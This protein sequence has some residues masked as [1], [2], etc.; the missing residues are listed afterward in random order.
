V[1]LV[2]PTLNNFSG[3]IDLMKSAQNGSLKPTCIVVWDNSG[4]KGFTDYCEQVGFS[5]AENVVVIES[6]KN[7]GCAYPWNK[8]IELC[9]KNYPKE[10]VCVS[11]DDI[12]LAHDT[13]EVFDKATR[14]RDSIL[15]CSGGIAA[16]NAFS[17][18]V[19]RYDRMQSVGVFDEMFIYPYCE[20]SDMARRIWFTGYDLDRV[21][22]CTIES[23][24][25]SATIKAYD[26]TDEEL[27]HI[28]FRRNAEYFYMKWG[29]DHNHIAVEYG[30]KEPWDGD[31]T[32]RQMAESYIRAQ[33]GE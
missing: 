7:R 12:V 22:D 26:A 2:T 13:L 1:I 16:P 8:M 17:L 21:V 23:H 31:D 9:Y 24:V 14:E 32:N 33:Y 29:T 18:F 20:D 5:L 28:R 25:G 4:N 19:T 3:C 27:H 30:Y 11:N 15:F 6:D 10:F